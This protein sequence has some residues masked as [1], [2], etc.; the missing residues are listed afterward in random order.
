LDKLSAHF[1]ELFHHLKNWNSKRKS[2]C[3]NCNKS[4]HT[5]ISKK[6][7]IL[8][9][10]LTIL[11][12]ILELELIKSIGF[13]NGMGGILTAGALGGLT[14]GIGI[15]LCLV[16]DLKNLNKHNNSV[17]PNGSQARHL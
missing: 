9:L 5:K 12:M 10:P 16:P 15:R 3:P 4:F 2:K 11:T 6:I 13:L 8:I 17:A 7:A 14:A 1:K